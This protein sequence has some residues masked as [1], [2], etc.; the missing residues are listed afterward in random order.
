MNV[1]AERGIPVA[2]STPPTWPGWRRP[3]SGSTQRGA[4]ADR[5]QP[6]GGTQP[7]PA[8]APTAPP[9]APHPAPQ[10]PGQEHRE[11]HPG[12]VALDFG[13]SSSTATLYDE[14]I[15]PFGAISPA[16]RAK[17]SSELVKVIGERPDRI[18][19]IVYREWRQLVERVAKRL[20]RG[21]PAAADGPAAVTRLIALLDGSIRVDEGLLDQAILE[22]ERARYTCS[23][24]LRRFLDDRLNR[25]YDAAFYEPPLDLL[26]LFKV[27]LL[28]S[29][30]DEIPSVLYVPDDDLG[31]ATMSPP[32]EQASTRDDGGAGHEVR[33][34]RGLKQQLGRQTPISGS[35]FSTTELIGRGIEDL[36]DRSN[37]YLTQFRSRE[38]FAPGELG[39]V[40][41]TYPTMAPPAVREMLADMV[42]KS[43]AIKVITSF[44]EAIA[45]AMFFVM[46][47]FGGT[48]D[49]SVEAFAARSHSIP[50]R[51]DGDARPREWQQ[52]VLIIDIG[53][54]TTD[55][56]LLRLQLS[57]ETPVREG[58]TSP[59]YGR[60]YKLTP[61]LLGTTGDTHRG[62]DHLT[63][64][65]FQWLKTV[66]ADHLLV[67]GDGDMARFVDQFPLFKSPDGAYIPGSLI[68][69]TLKEPAGGRQEAQDFAELIIP[70]RWAAA[71]PGEEAEP[72]QTFYLLWD[73]AERAKLQLGR[74]SEY[75]LQEANLKLIMSRIPT[76]GQP[77]PTVPSTALL[78]ADFE[79]LVRP[80]LTDVM[81][82]TADLVR[83]QL[84]GDNGRRLDRV[85]FTGR[86][87]RMSLIREV[88]VTVFSERTG[89][90]TPLIE[91]DPSAVW[92]EDSYAKHATSIGA[93]WAESIRRGSQRNPDNLH[94]RLK[95]G[96]VW[97]QIDVENLFFFLRGT[98]ELGGPAE[99]GALAAQ[100]LFRT[101]TP[102]ADLYGD[103][104]LLVRNEE[105]IELTESFI[106]HRSEGTRPHWCNFQVE[107]YLQKAPE[108]GF[109]PNEAIWPRQ[110]YAQVEVTPDLDMY[111]LLCR[112]KDPHYVV[113][114]DGCD[115]LGKL[116][117]R[118]D[119]D[120]GVRLTE[121]PAS[122]VV[123]PGIPGA[124][125]SAGRLEPVFAAGPAEEIFTATFVAGEGPDEATF[126]GAISGRLP[127]PGPEGWKFYL[128]REG[129][130]DTLLAVIDH[131]QAHLPDGLLSRGGQRQ[132]FFTATLDE[133]GQLCV[134]RGQPRFRAA[135]TLSAVE[136][137]P[138]AVFRTRMSSMDPTYLKDNDAFSGTH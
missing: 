109:T 11:F 48:F 128:H 123:D 18:G 10:P 4:G 84:T 8:P 106:I 96:T 5:A 115:V 57:D 14:G 119:T 60:F 15:R 78:P 113:P 112:G 12:L 33:P 26:R 25:C 56:A 35:G 63:L 85:I 3:P 6:S 98:F 23:E 2:D 129:S 9:A 59:Q 130:E 69:A 30:Q 42:R 120:G 32:A 44:D 76:V 54:G 107:A 99:P 50:A 117:G 47:E 64:L 137:T 20:L 28:T 102:F 43:G 55:V 40:L 74:G 105:W 111:I 118:Q 27:Q 53:G 92:I 127:A 49:P 36:L 138:G 19:A 46:R 38:H 121:L 37:R 114:A 65:V 83:D 135:S 90:G 77:V 132:V 79:G 131:D 126:R 62:G 29:G 101:G 108:P 91:W 24:G 7:P 52:H 95:D 22:I 66:I 45:A 1:Q 97:L 61:W 122:I 13:T 88:L 16:Q 94:E 70:T 134:H 136:Q 51:S 100:K 81:R 125:V 31:R 72:R 133:R 116:S 104:A 82:L 86:S 17:L 89:E 93:C 75:Q 58:S 67:Q 80:D 103:G 21:Q 34:Y 71:E 68:E 39:N 41:V 110:M 124:M 73:E 87:S